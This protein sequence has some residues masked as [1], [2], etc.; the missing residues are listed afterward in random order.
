MTDADESASVSLDDDDVL[1]A[2]LD[3]P[4]TELTTDELMAIK[5]TFRAHYIW[6]YNAVPWASVAPLVAV[7][8]IYSKAFLETLAKHHA[9]AFSDAVKA[10]IRARGPNREL[11]VGPEDGSAARIV[12]TTETPDEARLALLD[13][14]VT[15]DE[16]RGKFLRWNED[17][18][19]WRADS[20]DEPDRKS[21]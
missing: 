6:F 15:S 21:R 20:G 16:S 2:L 17:A 18:K 13:L 10:R 14:D 9:D 4:F 7:V 11:V 12:I 3:R 1:S 19:A 8:A 5:A